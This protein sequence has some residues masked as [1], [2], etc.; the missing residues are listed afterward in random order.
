MGSKFGVYKFLVFSK[1]KLVTAYLLFF[2]KITSQFSMVKSLYSSER[3]LFEFLHQYFYINKRIISMSITEVR[4]WLIHTYKSKN[5]W[6]QVS[7]LTSIKKK[8][9]RMILYSSQCFCLLDK[10]VFDI[11]SLRICRSFSQATANCSLFKYPNGSH[12]AQ[13]KILWIFESILDGSLIS[14]PNNS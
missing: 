5:V 4:S 12:W 10:F 8:K 11:R 2:P 13:E 6:D 14:I 1:F 7:H 9:K 3:N